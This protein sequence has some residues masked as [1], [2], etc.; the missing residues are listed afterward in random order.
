MTLTSRSGRQSVRRGICKPGNNINQINKS[1]T[2]SDTFSSRL[3]SIIAK[4][5]P[6]LWIHGDTHVSC[7][8][9]I[10]GTRVVCNPRGYPSE[11]SAKGFAPGLIAKL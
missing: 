4:Y 7:D 2:F 8:Y 6:E 1:D 11:S 9:E 3:Q 10:F 5:Q